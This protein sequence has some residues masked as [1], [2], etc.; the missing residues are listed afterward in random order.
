MMSAKSCKSSVYDGDP[1]NGLSREDLRTMRRDKPAG[2]TYKERVA[3]VEKYLTIGEIPSAQLPERLVAQTYTHLTQL[4]LLHT[5][6]KVVGASYA[7]SRSSSTLQGDKSGLP[8]PA[9]VRIALRTTTETGIAGYST[10]RRV[11]RGSQTCEPLEEASLIRDS[12][13]HVIS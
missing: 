5:Y 10:H 8:D 7:L 6:P 9:G 11:N 2:L 12:Q 3:L 13:Q 1:R 4:P